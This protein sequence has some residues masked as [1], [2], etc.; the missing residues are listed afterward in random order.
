M[1]IQ[2]LHA[3]TGIVT[4]VAWPTTWSQRVILWASGWQ[5]CGLGRWLCPRYYELGAPP[6]VR[7]PHCRGTFCGSLHCD[8]DGCPW[9]DAQGWV[10]ARDHLR[11]HRHQKRVRTI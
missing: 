5:R 8:D 10:H 9:R 11:S 7:C 3:P 2:R 6:V 4:A 1:R